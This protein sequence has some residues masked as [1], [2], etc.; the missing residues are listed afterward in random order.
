MKIKDWA[1]QR[2]T[3][4]IEKRAMDRLAKAAEGIAARAKGRVPVDTGKL[5]DSIRVTRLP[6]DPK[7]NVRVY[8]GGRW[9]GAPFYAHMI[10][11][12]TSKMAAK[13]FLRPSLNESKGNIMSTLENG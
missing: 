9:K 4:Q 1:P 13:P 12:G 3:E 6:G 8:S 5:R 11:Y 7:L 10:E 2:I